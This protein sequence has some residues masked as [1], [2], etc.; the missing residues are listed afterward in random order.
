MVGAE[1]YGV[2]RNLLAPQRP[3]DKSFDELKEVLIES[4]STKPILIEER[5]IICSSLLLTLTL[6]NIENILSWS[7]AKCH[8]S[9]VVGRCRGSWVVGRGCG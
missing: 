4:Y 1:A 6:I 8:G 7:V 2:I 5:V 9:W 3:N